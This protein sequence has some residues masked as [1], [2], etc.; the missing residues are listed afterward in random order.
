MNFVYVLFMASANRARKAVG[1]IRKA[2]GI[3]ISGNGFDHL[4][5]HY[6]KGRLAVIK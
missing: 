2:L 1:A 4:H 6:L 3:E 5:W